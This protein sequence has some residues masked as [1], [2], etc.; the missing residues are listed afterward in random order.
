MSDDPAATTNVPQISGKMPK[1]AGLDSGRNLVPIRKWIGLVPV[2]TKN[3]TASTPRTATIPT[4][5]RIVTE[6]QAR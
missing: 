5:V 6:A 4:V 1:S 2:T 3:R